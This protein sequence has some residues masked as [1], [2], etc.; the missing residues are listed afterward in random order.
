MGCATCH[1]V[2]APTLAGLYMSKVDIVGGGTINA[3][4]DYLPR[5]DPRLWAQKSSKATPTSCPAI[6]GQI[7]E[8]QLFDLI[9]Y[10]KSLQ[11]S[12]DQIH[13]SPDRPL[14]PAINHADPMEQDNYA[15][16]VQQAPSQEMF[17]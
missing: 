14:T 6:R 7:T 16:P 10:I 11:N 17:K 13:I 15:K 4:E 3:D 5:I 1:G 9:S 2:Q 8:E 12:V